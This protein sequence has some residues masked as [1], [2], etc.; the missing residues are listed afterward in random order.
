MGNIIAFEILFLI[1]PAVEVV[2]D[3]WFGNGIVSLF[4]LPGI[5]ASS[6]F[7]T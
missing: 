5:E 2:A 1:F 4:A 7:H 6:S 3:L